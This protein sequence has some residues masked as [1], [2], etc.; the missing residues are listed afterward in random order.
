LGRRWFRDAAA[1][2]ARCHAGLA[3]LARSHL[4]I[5]GVIRLEAEFDGQEISFE[6]SYRLKRVNV[7]V[8]F[9]S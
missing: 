5:G 7:P 3:A 2:D 9:P 1:A 4:L 6:V 8:R